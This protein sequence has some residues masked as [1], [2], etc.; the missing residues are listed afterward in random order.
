VNKGVCEIP[1][2]RESLTQ[3]QHRVTEQSKEPG[4]TAGISTSSGPDE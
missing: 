4:Y 1:G 2:R 3:A